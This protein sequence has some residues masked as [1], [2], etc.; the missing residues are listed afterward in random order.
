M[1]PE[2]EAR[3][4]QSG[5]ADARSR[6][7][8]V[9]LHIGPD[10]IISPFVTHWSR[11][12]YYDLYTGDAGGGAQGSGAVNNGGS[13]QA[14]PESHGNNTEELVARKDP[15]HDDWIP[16]FRTPIEAAAILLGIYI[17]IY[18]TVAG[19]V[20][21]LGSPDTAA[22]TAAGASIATHSAAPVAAPE[23]SQRESIGEAGELSTRSDV[24]NHDYVD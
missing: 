10:G 5:D 21:A 22:A 15:D 3:R 18:L 17:A 9:V 13:R 7:R 1:N 24:A 12:L 11:I 6:G 23:M 14:A 8:P 19:L 2:A 20:H 16:R 4:R